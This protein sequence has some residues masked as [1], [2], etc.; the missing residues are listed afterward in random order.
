MSKV[1]PVNQQNF[2]AEVLQSELPVVVDF[3]ATWCPPCR[4]LTPILERLATEFDGQIRFVKINSD[5]EPQL[6]GH[7][8]VTGL[9]TIVLFDRGNHVAQFAGLPQEDAF[10]GQLKQ[11]LADRKVA[12]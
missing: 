10:R 2:Q 9:P 12:Q 11:W 5:E 1:L 4:M 3:Y 6:A 8:N 7:Y